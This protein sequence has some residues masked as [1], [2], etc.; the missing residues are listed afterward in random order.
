MLT[1]LT[2]NCGWRNIVLLCSLDR[3]KLYFFI[4]K[5]PIM[6]NIKQYELKCVPVITIN[7]CKYDTSNIKIL[8]KAIGVY[9]HWVGLWGQKY[10]FALSQEILW[11]KISAQKYSFALYFNWDAMN[12]AEISFC[13]VKAKTRGGG[14][15]QLNQQKWSVVPLWQKL[16]AGFKTGWWLEQ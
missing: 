2:E 14:R 12:C 13:S 5:K 15:H 9:R 4:D 6:K 16:R 1:A 11:R 3:A 10:S 8:S 7:L